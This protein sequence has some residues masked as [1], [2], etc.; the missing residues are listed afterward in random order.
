M[1]EHEIE[2]LIRKLIVALGEDPEREG[3]KKT[4]QRVAASLKFLTQG[5][6]K[7]LA[8]VLNIPASLTKQSSLNKGLEPNTGS[9]FVVWERDIR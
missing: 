9:T 4:P 1:S 3:L 2:G 8:Q 6:S 7:E 5:C